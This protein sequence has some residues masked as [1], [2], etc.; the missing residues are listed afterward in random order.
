MKAVLTCALHGC[1]RLLCGSDGG[2]DP[3]R[4]GCELLL[5]GI[6]RVEKEEWQ[7]KRNIYPPVRRAAVLVV[8]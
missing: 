7:R 8:S 4:G 1:R 5:G 3:L 6:G 2:D